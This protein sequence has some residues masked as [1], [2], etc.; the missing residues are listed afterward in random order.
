MS[1]SCRPDQPPL[2]PVGADTGSAPTTPKIPSFA[3]FVRADGRRLPAE[4]GQRSATIAPS[5]C[6][7]CRQ[8]GWRC[9]ARSQAPVILI[10]VRARY[11]FSPCGLGR[12]TQREA[13]QLA[14]L[15]ARNRC[16]RTLVGADPVS[17]RENLRPACVTRPPR[18]LVRED[19]RRLSAPRSQGYMLTHV[20]PYGT[21]CGTFN[22]LRP[23]TGAAMSSPPR[24]NNPPRRDHLPAASRTP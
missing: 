19:D 24:R 22:P 9:L 14:P 15:S 2:T 4:R 6:R 23:H 11:R 3:P 20:W 7:R 10:A 18:T 5:A 8:G 1:V 17:A 12:R 21:T 13:I 16:P